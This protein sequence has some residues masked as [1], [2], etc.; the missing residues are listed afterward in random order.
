LP[1]L[2]GQDT[3]QMLPLFELSLLK[4][5]LINKVLIKLYIYYIKL[6][7]CVKQFIEETQENVPFKNKVEIH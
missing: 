6:P 4:M 5:P 1:L 3:L 7:L 2:I